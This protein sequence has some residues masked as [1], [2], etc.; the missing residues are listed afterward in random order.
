MEYPVD[1]IAFLKCSVL[2]HYGFKPSKRLVIEFLSLTQPREDIS[3][4]GSLFIKYIEEKGMNVSLD[5]SDTIRATFLAFD[6]MGRGFIGKEDLQSVTKVVLPSLNQLH[7]DHM[8]RQLDSDGDGCL[9]YKDFEKLMKFK[10]E[11]V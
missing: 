6:T 1:V 5:T 10:L 9:T 4:L 3:K 11:E 8:F 2:S 7:V